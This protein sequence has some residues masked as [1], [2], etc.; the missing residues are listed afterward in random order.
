M[1]ASIM[2]RC[3]LIALVVLAACSG[4][5]STSA[6]DSGLG[7]EDGSTNSG[8]G[9]NA[10]TDADPGGADASCAPLTI[11]PPTNTCPGAPAGADAEAIAALDVINARR[12]AMGI[13]CQTQVASINTSAG[14]HCEYYAGNSG[15]CIANPHAEVSTCNLFVSEQFSGRMS[16]AGYSG[17]PAFEDMA[18]SGNG[19]ASA[20][21]WIDSVWHRTPILSPWVGD[22][23]YGHA[24]GCDTMDFGRGAQSAGDLVTAYPYNG[25]GSV[26]TSF[27]GNEGPRPPAPSNGFPSGYPIHLFARN[28]TVTSHVLHVKCDP[29]E[30]PHVWVEP[31]DSSGLL[32]DEFVMYA[33]DP[34]Q[35]GTTYVAEFAGTQGGAAF[36]YTTEFTTR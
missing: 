36:R 10:S 19:T 28:A 32:R 15:A 16:A 2:S 35:A 27:S 21:Q 26:P 17:S 30:L 25:E 6:S 13:G 4:D 7:S 29:T 12:L 23:G 20:N 14:L 18:F 3:A 11:A 5:G 8:D 34:L 9:G 1:I 24:A 22:H 33:D 31:A